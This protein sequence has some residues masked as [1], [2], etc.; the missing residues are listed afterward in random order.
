MLNEKAFIAWL[1]KQPDPGTAD[2]C[3]VPPEFQHMI[4]QGSV[5]RATFHTYRDP[6]TL[7][8]RVGIG[9]HIAAVMLAD[10]LQLPELGIFS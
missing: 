3:D 10:S 9:T 2:H 1:W 7:R 4:P 5:P 8:M 6:L